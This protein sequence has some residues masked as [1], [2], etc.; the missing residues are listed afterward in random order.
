[1]SLK[2]LII[3]CTY[4]SWSSWT[5]ALHQAFHSP[6]P[7]IGRCWSAVAVSIWNIL[8]R[9]LANK[10]CQD[11]TGG[12]WWG[13][14]MTCKESRF[15]QGKLECQKVPFWF[16]LDPLLPGHMDCLLFIFKFSLI[17]TSSNKFKISFSSSFWGLSRMVVLRGRVRESV[18]FALLIEPEL[19][20]CPIILA[21]DI[22]FFL[23]GSP[24]L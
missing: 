19:L 10:F 1:M 12:T 22:F 3:V 7:G 2:S 15:C 5:H 20:P 13:T 23:G 14:L 4:W 24:F 11:V 8:S 6:R 21:M 18:E 9:K 16:L 17:N